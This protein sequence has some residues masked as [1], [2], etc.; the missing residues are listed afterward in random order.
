VSPARRMASV[1]EQLEALLRGTDF[2]DEPTARTMRA[3][4]RERLQEDRPL[5]VYCGYDPTSVDLT[6]GHT[7]TMRKLRQFQDF[8][9]RVTF[10]IGNFTGL[11]GDPTDKNKTRPMLSPEQLEANARTYAAQAFRILDAERTAVRYNADWLSKLMFAE[12][13]QLAAHYTVAQFL[14][15]ESFQKRYA[16]HEPIHLSEFLYAIM[17][18]R[19]AVELE[20]DVQVGGRDQLFNLMAGR[21]LQ[22]EFGQ[23]PQV[24]IT[25]PLLVGT[26]GHEK[27]S[28][29]L[30]NYIALTD[31]AND[32]F[33]KVMS[34]PDH[35]M[36]D[37]F[38]LLTSTPL[39]EIDAI[40]GGS[41]MEAKKRLALD[42]T[43]GL[44]GARAA[45]EARDYFEAT[46]QRRET[47]LEMQ[48]HA[49]SSDPE[50]A[51]LDRIL[52][53]A[54]LAKSAAE[55][56]R[57]VEQGAVEVN[58]ARATDFA[59]ALRAGDEV[60]VGRHRFLRVVAG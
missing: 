12:V 17:Q 50:G 18:A 45:T 27:M 48:E 22:R 20:T 37:Y 24:V 56:R 30:G 42:I 26:D 14:E 36:R 16:A 11:V 29:S 10:L 19:D 47:P 40:L 57:L 44:N 35:A 55:V 34:L 21:P 60:K 1:E 31:S 52:R 58:G 3:E 15:R 59:F 51:R 4:L 8:G 9:H 53:D 13:I 33:G 43:A 39:G 2:G 49:L 32:M 46:I 38:V 25:L 54:G 23:K 6:L 7:L 41:P 28:K 5:N